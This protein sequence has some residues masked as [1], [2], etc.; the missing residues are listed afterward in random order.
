MAVSGPSRRHGWILRVR[1]GPENGLDSFG[2]FLG[3]GDPFS[4]VLPRNVKYS[5]KLTSAGLGLLIGKF[6]QR[7]LCE[8]PRRCLRTMFE[9]A[10]DSGQL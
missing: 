10:H 2:D 9:G 8:S 3:I 4:D 6:S 1:V 7:D 5:C